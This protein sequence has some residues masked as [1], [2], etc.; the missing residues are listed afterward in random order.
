VPPAST[1][2]GNVIVSLPPGGGALAGRPTDIRM[3]I[4]FLRI[5]KPHIPVK[6]MKVLT[7]RKYC[8]G[9]VATII[10]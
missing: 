7:I 10:S 1:T 3:V 6:N 8:I 2:V 4:R 5:I 9:M